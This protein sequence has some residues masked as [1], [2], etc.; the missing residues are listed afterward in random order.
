MTVEPGGHEPVALDLDDA[1]GWLRR[2]ATLADEGER[3]GAAWAYWQG[4][5]A[6]YR[7]GALAD[8]TAACRMALVALGALT[9]PRLVGRVRLLESLI[10]HERGDD[11]R[12]TVGSVAAERAFQAARDRDGFLAVWS[13]RTLRALGHGDRD[14]GLTMLRWMLPWLDEV[15][16]TTLRLWLRIY[17]GD[18]LTRDHLPEDGLGWLVEALEL[19]PAG[20]GAHL[21]AAAIAMQA[22]EALGRPVDAARIGV[23][24]V[25]APHLAPPTVRA[26][27]YRLLAVALR[28]C[29]QPTLAMACE[30][31][32]AEL[33][34]G[35]A[36]TP[37]MLAGAGTALAPLF[38]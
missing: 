13:A 34:A 4:A 36:P 7:A 3:E 5:A 26:W 10:D 6:A 22:F 32:G 25:D 8:A 29:D 37:P 21:A 14:A 17:A 9:R 15:G 11:E 12:A 28:R 30:D 1:A 35:A 38:G 16:P 23:V 2:A 27:L 20:S 24:A 18:R 19:A 31:A 33:V